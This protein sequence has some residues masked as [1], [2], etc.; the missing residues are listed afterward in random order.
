MPHFSRQCRLQPA[1]D[2]DWWNPSLLRDNAKPFCL[3]L[4][5]LR[6]RTWCSFGCLQHNRAHD[7]M[8]LA[9][10]SLSQMNRKPDYCLPLSGCCIICAGS[11][12]VA[13]RSHLPLAGSGRPTDDFARIEDIVGVIGV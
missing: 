11:P 7:T 12:G 4:L 8:C 6:R 10:I 3:L 5:L 2:A 13:R 1:T 9:A